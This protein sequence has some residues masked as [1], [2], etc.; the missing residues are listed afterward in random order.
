MAI[1]AGAGMWQSGSMSSTP[2]RPE[3]K[4]EPPVDEETE[5]TVRE[6]EATFDQD[7]KTAALWPD[8]KARIVKQSTPR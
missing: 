1:E 8:A 7:R 4:P 5:P 6:R 3:T 2:T